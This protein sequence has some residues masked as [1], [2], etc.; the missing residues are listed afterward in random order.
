[1]NEMD[2][3]PSIWRYGLALL[4]VIV[5]FAAFAWYLLSG[6][7]GS[8]GGLTQMAAP[9]EIELDL[10]EPGEYTIFYENESYFDGR[11]YIT[12]GQIP[13]LDIAVVE[14][15]SGRRLQT[16]PPAGSSTYNIGGR[17]GQSVMAFRAD[18]A[19]IYVMNASYPSEPGPEVILAVGKDILEDILL[20]VGISIAIIFVSLSI[21]A[22]IAYTTYVRRRKAML[23][24]ER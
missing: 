1:M 17:S 9:G 6:I 20:M 8:L 21:A 10:G 11:F 14:K 2:I 7:S 19:G 16:Y 5:G 18:V 23:K 24:T 4:I 13:G 12:A 22:Y 3:S 15:A